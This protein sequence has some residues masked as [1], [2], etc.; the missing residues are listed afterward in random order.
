M[1]SNHKLQQQQQQRPCVARKTGRKNITS[2]FTYCSVADF[3]RFIVAVEIFSKITLDAP[4]FLTTTYC[5]WSV[6]ALL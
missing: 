2:K 4:L 1:Q 3:V 6:G 5:S